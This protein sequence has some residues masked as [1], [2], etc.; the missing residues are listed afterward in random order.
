MLSLRKKVLCACSMVLAFMGN[1]ADVCVLPSGAVKNIEYQSSKVP[2]YLAFDAVIDSKVKSTADGAWG[3]AVRLNDNALLA[4]ELVNK[5]FCIKLNKSKISYIDDN[6][7]LFLPYS[8]NKRINK[9]FVFKVTGLAKAGKNTLQLTN[10]YDFY[11][12]SQVKISNLRW[13][14]SLPAANKTVTPQVK[15]QRLSGFISIPLGGKKVITVEKNSGKLPY[16]AFSGRIDTAKWRSGA[17][18]ALIIRVNGQGL[19]LDRLKNKS[20][21][22]HF[23]SDIRLKWLT[24]DRIYLGYYPIHKVKG[25]VD[26]HFIHDFVFDMSGLWKKDGVN[27]IELENIFAAFP[28]SSVQIFDLRLSDNNFLRSSYVNESEVTSFG[29]AELR[30]K[31]EGMHR[32]VDKLLD[33][34]PERKAVKQ[35][36][37]FV[38]QVSRTAK[39][40]ISAESNGVKFAAAEN[41]L[42]TTAYSVRNQRSVLQNNSL[43]TDYLSVERK[44]KNTQYGVIVY[45]KLTNRTNKDLPVVC[46]YGFKL[47]LKKLQEFRIAGEAQQRFIASTNNFVA[48]K[49]SQTPL[50]YLGMKQGSFGI[51]LTDDVLRNQ[52]SVFTV[53]DTLYIADDIFYLQPQQSYTISF[54]IYPMTGNYYDC[55]NILRKDLNLYQ[56]MPGLFG[57]VYKLNKEDYFERYYRKKLDTPEKI[58]QFFASSGINIPAATGTPMLYGSEKSSEWKKSLKPYE[59]FKRDTVAANVP[60]KAFLHYC[61]VHLVAVNKNKDLDG[62]TKWQERLR[63]SV[64]LDDQGYTVPYRAGKLYL[65]V[66][67]LENSAGKQIKENLAYVLNAHSKNGIFFDEF[68]HSR[69]RLAWNMSDNYSALLDKNGNI[70]RKFAIVPL[71]SHE[72]LLDIARFAVQKNRINYVNQFDCTLPLMQLPLVHFAE[73]VAH[74]ESYLIRAA[75]ASRTPLTLSC[76]RNTTVW[77]DI[78]YFLQYGVAVCYYA[79]RSYGD[80]LLKKLYPLT[81]YEAQPGVIYGKDKL[82]TCRS[83]SYKLPGAKKLTVYIYRDPA[84]MLSE[85]R[86]VSGDTV[87]LKL[88]PAREVALITVDVVQ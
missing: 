24:D 65:V 45:D 63:D 59:K 16:L 61:D 2:V 79:S 5:P 51:Y 68:N 28:G 42:L 21:Y 74:E 20:P 53:D 64:L 6:G 10:I 78:K 19:R 71:K 30:R 29:A 40:A 39:M 82:L 43:Q 55:L 7:R 85:T 37:K 76:K 57:F 87:D 75:Q 73:P 38:P 58:R 52:Y 84:G 66:P 33:T 12:K 69:S 18:P 22:F 46:Q 44:L 50:I 49:Y 26:K 54:R 3:L 36:I 31:A 8:G 14:D 4:S 1:A 77:S 32:G 27:V 13:L 56:E 88:D 86:N 23:R 35:I 48:R 72:F 9:S 81:I 62:K 83:G 67:T 11:K 47:D 80:H 17:Q 34:A 41:L 25:T 15:N 60:V 70:T